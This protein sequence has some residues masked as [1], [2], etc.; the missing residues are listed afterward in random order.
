MSIKLQLRQFEIKVVENKTP[1]FVAT[2]KN[3]D[4]TV[5]KL[6][7]FLKDKYMQQE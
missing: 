7:C 6:L 1:V 3:I 4:E 2:G 5:R